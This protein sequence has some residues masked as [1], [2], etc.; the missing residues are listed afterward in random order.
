M[1]EYHVKDTIESI[2][3]GVLSC[4]GKDIT[5]AESLEILGAL[6]VVKDAIYEFSG[7]RIYCCDHNYEVC[8][9]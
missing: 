8:K 9:G 3:V 4:Q 7:Y 6:T 1:T 2:M 5:V